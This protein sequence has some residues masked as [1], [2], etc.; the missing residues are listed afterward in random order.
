M[1]LCDMKLKAGFQPTAGLK[2][3]DWKTLCRTEYR[4]LIY[5]GFKPR[6][7]T[8]RL[9]PNAS[10]REEKYPKL[11]LELNELNIVAQLTS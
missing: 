9:K 8:L 2:R 7:F 4:I 3:S 1:L 6:S 5:Q 11:S 10:S